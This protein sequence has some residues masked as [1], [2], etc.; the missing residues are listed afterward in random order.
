MK[1]I[2]EI[3]QQR[4]E[5]LAE[6]EHIRELGFDPDKVLTSADIINEQRYSNGSNGDE[7]ASKAHAGEREWRGGLEQQ[8][9]KARE[10]AKF[11]IKPEESKG[12]MV[13]DKVI[14]NTKIYNVSK[15]DSAQKVWLVGANDTPVKQ[16]QLEGPVLIDVEGKKTRAWMLRK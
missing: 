11:T 5:L 6:I 9:A 12:V 3:E 15:W 13:G 2:R 8:T 10:P 4:Q 16:E 14:Y 7:R 1:L